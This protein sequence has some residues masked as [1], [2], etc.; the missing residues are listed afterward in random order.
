MKFYEFIVVIIVFGIILSVLLVGGQIN[1][2]SNLQNNYNKE[3]SSEKINNGIEL[4]FDSKEIQRIYPFTGAFPTNELAYLTKLKNVDRSNMTNEFILRTAFA[5]VTK[6]DWADSY[7]AEDEP[8]EIDAKILEEYIEDIFGDVEYKH[9]DFDNKDISIDEAVTNLYENEYDPK[10]NTYTINTMAGDGME[11]SYMI[12]HTVN[13]IKNGDRI[14]ITI[15]PIYVDNLGQKENKDGYYAFFY[16][17]YSS[18][19]FKTEKFDGELTGE[20]ETTIYDESYENFVEEIKEI[21]VEDLETYKLTYRL[22]GKTNKYEFESL[23]F[24]K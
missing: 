8:L 20:I 22:N 1:K 10:T 13:A 3:L 14:E 7:I 18:Y 15:N 4:E 16:K 23:K 5:K 19:D 11:D 21:N 9:G 2:I 12:E 24:E 6:E 17:C